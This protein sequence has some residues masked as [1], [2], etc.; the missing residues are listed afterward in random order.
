MYHYTRL[1]LLATI[2]LSTGIAALAAKASG[3]ND[4]RHLPPA[5]ASLG[6]A[7]AAAEQHLHGRAVR[8]EFE[9]SRHGWVY[10][11]E[12]VQGVKVF[13]VQVDAQTASVIAATE[14]HVD[15]DDGRDKQD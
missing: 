6:Q 3:D 1:G 11:V 5:K 4:A 12:V 15:H 14:D 2:I 10:D 13:D 7:V 9:P 8:A